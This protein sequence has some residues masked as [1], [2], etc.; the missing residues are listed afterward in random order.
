MGKG[1]NAGKQHFLLFPQRFLHFSKQILSFSLSFI[2]ST[3][4]AF[5]LE[6]SK[7]L[8]CG[9]GLITLQENA[10]ENIVAKGDNTGGKH[11]HLFATM[12]STLPQIETIIIPR[13]NYVFRCILESASLSV[14]L[15]DYLSVCV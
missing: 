3:A 7:T 12:F 1:E 10:F 14:R 9:K 2:L 4:N 6:Q 8:S 11:L 13:Q 5:N 15:S